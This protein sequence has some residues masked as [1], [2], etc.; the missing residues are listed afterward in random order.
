M[1]LDQLLASYSDEKL[2]Q[3]VHK[4]NHQPEEFDFE[5]YRLE[6]QSFTPPPTT[7]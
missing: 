5:A 7:E 2:F 4:F 3:W 6:M 1:L